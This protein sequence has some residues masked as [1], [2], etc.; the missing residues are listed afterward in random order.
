[1]SRHQILNLCKNDNLNNN[2]MNRMNNERDIRINKKFIN[3]PN[4]HPPII[5][6]SNGYAQYAQYNNNVN[7][8]DFNTLTNAFNIISDYNK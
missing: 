4:K 8:T 3:K 1:M 7:I 2:L 6:Y 5:P